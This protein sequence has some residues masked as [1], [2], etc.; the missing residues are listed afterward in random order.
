MD[1]S[2][3]SSQGAEILG[4]PGGVPSI[5]ADGAR[6]GIVWLIESSPALRAYDAGDLSRE[7]FRGALDSYVKFSVPT[8]AKGKVFAATQNSLEVFG[9]LPALKRKVR[10]ANNAGQL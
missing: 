4:F 6:G 9:L 1:C 3:Q 8:I 7:L 10:T 5:S 2:R